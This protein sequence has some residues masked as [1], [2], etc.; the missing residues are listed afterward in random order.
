MHAYVGLSA[1]RALRLRDN[2]VQLLT[3]A[4]WLFAHEPLQFIRHCLRSHAYTV[5]LLPSQMRG[6]E[7][8]LRTFAALHVVLRVCGQLF[9]K[10]SDLLYLS[11][12]QVRG[13]SFP[14][15]LFLIII[16]IRTYGPRGAA[17]LG[18]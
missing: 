15:F 5:L 2:N 11:Y 1:T 4:T 3:A 6:G 9:G 10:D 18:N 12:L 7:H 14:V 8:R 17:L 16:I 13:Y